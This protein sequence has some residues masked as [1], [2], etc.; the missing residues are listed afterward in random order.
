MIDTLETSNTIRIYSPRFGVLI[1]NL[2]YLIHVT[3]VDEHHTMNTLVWSRD[4]ESLP[5]YI[6]KVLGFKF[7]KPGPVPPNRDES[8]PAFFRRRDRVAKSLGIK[9]VV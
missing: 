9:G 4:E 2:G 7:T 5:A 3:F 6:R 1:R 8:E